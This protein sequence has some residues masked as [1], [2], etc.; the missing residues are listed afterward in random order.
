MHRNNSIFRYRH[1]RPL[2]LLFLFLTTTILSASV[3]TPI[4]SNAH[5]NKIERNIYFYHG[6]HLGSAS[7]ITEH[8]GAPIQYIHYAPYGEMIANQTPYDMTFD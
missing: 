1:F 3:Y 2:L 4:S 7:W 5:Y 6:D 8:H